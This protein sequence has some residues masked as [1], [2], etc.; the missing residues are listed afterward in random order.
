MEI[1][2]LN[3]IKICLILSPLFISFNA[4]GQSSDNLV[5]ESVE[6]LASDFI[7]SAAYKIQYDIQRELQTKITEATNSLNQKS[8]ESKLIDRQIKKLN[9]NKQDYIETI[10]RYETWLRGFD[11]QV[12]KD[13]IKNLD[14]ISASIQERIRTFEDNIV[15]EK[16]NISDL[17]QKL[18]VIDTIIEWN[19][20][21]IVAKHQNEL[22]KPFSTLT[23]TTIDKIEAE[24]N[25]YN[26]NAM[27]SLFIKRI[28]DIRQYKTTYDNGIALLDTKYDSKQVE[29]TIN[30]LKLQFAKLCQEQQPEYEELIRKLEMYDDGMKLMC[31]YFNHINSKR[32]GRNYSIYDFSDDNSDY[33]RKYK[34]EINM[35]VDAIPYLKKAFDGFNKAL[36]N[37][38]NAH[39][40]IEKEILSYAGATE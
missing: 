12:L 5:V 27:V 35:Y 33:I 29:A 11:L 40:T 36:S 7:D 28:E 14:D 4:Y 25:E 8:K 26:E 19:A 20:R 13:S 22:K 23:Y 10:N 6:E 18:A 15:D 32:E 30:S 16:R 37:N 38:G 39:P 31:D 34:D 21:T 9:S 3:K 1:M 17:E 2:E 24:C